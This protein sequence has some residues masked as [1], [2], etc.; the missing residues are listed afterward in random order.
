MLQRPCYSDFEI[1]I[2]FT[3]GTNVTI[4]N[5][6]IEPNV[7]LSF[8]ASNFLF[9]AFGLDA[10]TTSSN[11][12]NAKLA[13]FFFTMP[14]GTCSTAELISISGFD[15]SFN[16]CEAFALQGVNIC[17]GDIS[18]S[19]TIVGLQPDLTEIDEMPDVTLTARV[20]N[21]PEF[22]YNATSNYVASSSDYN[23]D[24]IPATHAS[25]PVEVFVDRVLTGDIA[26]HNCEV[27]TIDIL[28]ISSFLLELPPS[29]STDPT[30]EFNIIQ[31]IAADVNG[32]GS[33]T[34]FDQLLIRKYLLD[35]PD[36]YDNIST[37][38]YPEQSTLNGLT[39]LAATDFIA[40][41]SAPKK[42]TYSPLLSHRQKV[43]FY[44]VKLGD[45]KKLTGD[46]YCNFSDFS[47]QGEAPIIAAK[48]FSSSQTQIK[49][50]SLSLRDG[51]EVL[52][53]ISVT[54]FNPN[55]ILSFGLELSPGLK[56]IGLESDLIDPS[57]LKEMYSIQAS[58]SLLK[59]LSLEGEFSGAL[60][61]SDNTLLSV[62]LKADRNISLS[63][64]TISLP[65]DFE[66]I[67][68]SFEKR[69]GD[70]SL[71]QL[72][73]VKSVTDEINTTVAPNPFVSNYTLRFDQPVT[74]KV[75]V[76]M[77]D[78]LGRV[79]FR[80]TEEANGSDLIIYAAQVA[81]LPSSAYILRV[82]L[83]DCRQTV[84]TLVKY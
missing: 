66:N 76:E 44:A 5:V 39:D 77:T 13:T 25:S 18:I 82:T 51:Q 31:K 36:N 14:V 16:P 24:N 49:L 58:G 32:N 61:S 9:G 29:S 2:A 27:T 4:T 33:I 45:V 72:T 17:N 63:K 38:A 15:C 7:D 30:N 62:R 57:E 69:H 35:D 75:T 71:I 55:S 80:S 40:T 28:A 68:A 3:L 19:G 64:E 81:Q 70:V 26:P 65:Q 20:V 41:F 52:V 42:I 50:P 10:L 83:P 1:D 60:N 34:A 54:S 12:P 84:Q 73:F 43:D 46:D 74:G 59:F 21:N 53:P 47:L 48:N 78:Q 8:D 23:I 6:I 11:I 79:V 56:V 22:S 37:T 67:Y